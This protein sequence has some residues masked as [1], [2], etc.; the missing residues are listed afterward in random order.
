MS[1][2]NEFADD[3]YQEAFIKLYKTL[4]KGNNIENMYAYLL[5]ICRNLIYNR[6]RNKIYFE[7]VEKA[8]DIVDLSSNIL[9]KKEFNTAVSDALDKLPSEHKEAFI[10]QVFD[11]MSYKEISNISNVPVS[12][13]RN[14]VVR[15]KRKLRQLLSTYLELKNN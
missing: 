3:I 7:D 13:V 2:S 11:G 14:R 5:T 6:A 12:T 4:E 15:A 9:E 1:G 8:N 10:L